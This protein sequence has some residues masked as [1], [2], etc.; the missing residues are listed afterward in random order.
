MSRQNIE[1]DHPELLSSGRVQLKV[2]DGR[3][4]VP[5]LG[6]YNAIHVGAAA[7]TLPQA[8]IDQ[9][10]V[11]EILRCG[12]RFLINFSLNL[13]SKYVFS[14]QAWFLFCTK[15]AKYMFYSCTCRYK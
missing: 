15:L 1:R 4:G 6:P 8:L 12:C 14:F 7:K 11:G 13:D 5:E 9:L 2:G 3:L 10:K